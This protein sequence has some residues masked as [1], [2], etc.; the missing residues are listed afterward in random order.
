MVELLSKL[1]IKN[2]ENIS[3]P[4]V[5]RGYGTMSGIVGIIANVLLFA[6]KFAVGTLTG[7]IS[8]SADA[9]NSLADAGTSVISLVSF[10]ISSKPADRKHPFGHARIEYVASMI[11]AFIILLIGFELLKSSVGK[12]IEP[13][14]TEFSIFTV[15]VLGAS[16][17]VKLGLYLFN[18]RI[19]KKIG[20]VVIKA[21]ATDSLSDAA[22]TTAVLL[23]ALISRFLGVDLDGYMGAVVAVM[24]MIAGVK[25]LNETKNSILGE[26][27]DAEVVESIKR[28]VNEYPEALGI[29]DMHIHNYGPERTVASFHVEVDGGGNI[30]ELHDA[31]DNMEKQVAEELSIEC[32]IHMDPIVTDD[33]RVE[34]LREAVKI[35]ALEIDKRLNIHDFRFVE[36]HTHTN[37]IFDVVAPFELKMTDDELVAAINGKNSELGKEYF[38]VITVDRE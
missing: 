19:S 28:V 36:G 26:A 10:K 4:A 13:T 24:I 3:D 33:A 15:I 12:I 7:S 38:T 9:V 23:S 32:T 20:S 34:E 2:R 21:T 16:V 35:R 22:A 1:F 5:R 29:H 37:L 6:G 14:G 11:V 17:L 31:I 30:F 8:I 18:M 25:V 27:P